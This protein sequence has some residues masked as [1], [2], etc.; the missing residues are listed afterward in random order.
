MNVL[1]CVEMWERRLKARSRNLQHCLCFSYCISSVICL[2][3]SNTT[4]QNTYIF[5]ASECSSTVCG[6]DITQSLRCCWH[7]LC[8]LIQMVRTHRW[9]KRDNSTTTFRS[10]CN[11]AA[12]DKF[13][14]IFAF[15]IAWQGYF[16]PSNLISV[17]QRD[18]H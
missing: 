17:S 15:S 9:S 5:C 13:L 1:T 14:H 4:Q 6:A 10:C 11:R 8:S 16:N 3:T 2:R 12:C 18:L 7:R